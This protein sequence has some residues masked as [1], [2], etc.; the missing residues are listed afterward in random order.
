VPSR[1]H[2]SVVD[3]SLG[4]GQCDSSFTRSIWFVLITASLRN[5]KKN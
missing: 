1:L 5:G 2:I 4:G 3:K